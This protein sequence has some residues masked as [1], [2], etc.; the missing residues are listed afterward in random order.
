M[1]QT[2]THRA[3]PRAWLP[4][5]LETVLRAATQVAL[6]LYHTATYC[7]L[8]TQGAETLH[9]CLVLAC[10]STASDLL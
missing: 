9:I 5:V 7:A 1:T 2:G 4:G 6:E 8:H 3:V 10:N